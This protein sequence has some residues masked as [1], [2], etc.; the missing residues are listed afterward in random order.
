MTLEELKQ[1]Y[2]QTEA[3]RLAEALRDDSAR[4]VVA[5]DGIKGSAY[6]FIAAQTAELLRMKSLLLMEAI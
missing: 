5:I 2:Y 4:P 3:K 6:A 1:K